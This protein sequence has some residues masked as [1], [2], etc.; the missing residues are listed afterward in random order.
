MNRKS[1]GSQ[2]YDIDTKLMTGKAGSLTQH[3]PASSQQAFVLVRRKGAEGQI[4]RLAAFDL[5]HREDVAT[6]GE[7]IDLASTGLQPEAEDLVALQH[8][9]YGGEPFGRV[10]RL[11]GAAAQRDPPAAFGADDLRRLQ[12]GRGPG[13]HRP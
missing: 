6:A 2:R 10:A 9:Q 4:Q 7:D 8:Q 1:A 12:P 3:R 13:G 11:T 5:D